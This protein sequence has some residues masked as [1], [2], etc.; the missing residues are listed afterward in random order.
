M[1]RGIT[2]DAVDAPVGT[3][4][5]HGPVLPGR[6]PNQSLARRWRC[7]EALDHRTRTIPG[8]DRP[9]HGQNPRPKCPP[10]GAAPPIR[11][12]AGTENAWMST[13]GPS[14]EELIDVTSGGGD[15]AAAKASGGGR[16]DQAKGKT[17]EL[18]DQAKQR[19]GD[20]QKKAGPYL[21]QAKDRASGLKE[22]AAPSGQSGG[23]QGG[24]VRR[25]SGWSRSA[26]SRECLRGPRQ[27]DRRQVLRQDQVSIRQAQSDAR[28]RPTA[29]RPT[30]S[31][32]SR[33]AGR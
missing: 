19:L 31:Y 10:V 12:R 2:R 7:P 28:P 8:A 11:R 27:G 6:R 13:T 17:G 30:E 22:K 26:R 9:H 23:G 15:S 29:R 5:R 4:Q 32:A 16:A 1:C 14:D 33:Q 25:Q 21:D 3:T 20:L 24:R 18:A